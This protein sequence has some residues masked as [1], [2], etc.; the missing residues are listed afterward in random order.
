MN[1]RYKVMAMRVIKLMEEQEFELNMQVFCDDEDIN[2]RRELKTCGTAMCI[3]GALAHL[4]E[5][6]EIFRKNYFTPE[7]FNFNYVPYGHTLLGHS[8]DASGKEEVVWDF[9][10]HGGWPS[11][12]E[13][14]IE[15]MNYIIEHGIPKD[16]NVWEELGYA[17]EEEPDTQY[18]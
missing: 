17:G 2:R 8:T 5:Y 1:Q 13:A 11:S 6:P 4:D 10:F 9:F 15:R 14:T 16:I 7:H 18:L 12:V 3:L